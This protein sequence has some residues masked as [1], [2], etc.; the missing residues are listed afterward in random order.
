MFLAERRPVVALDVLGERVGEVVPMFGVQPTQIAV[1][2]LFDRSNV[3]EI[4]DVIVRAHHVIAAHA[5]GYSPSSRTILGHL[6]SPGS[7]RR[8]NASMLSG[9]WVFAGYQISACRYDIANQAVDILNGIAAQ[10][11]Q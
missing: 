10:I 8:T 7:K 3:H 1:L 4:G 9:G 2:D 6:Q 5:G 11:R